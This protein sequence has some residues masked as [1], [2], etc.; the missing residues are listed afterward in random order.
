MV[1][2]VPN[3]IYDFYIY[4][5]MIVVDATDIPAKQ[6]TKWSVFPN[7]GT[8]DFYLRSSA[9]AHEKGYVSLYDL[10][11]RQLVRVPL[12]EASTPYQMGGCPQGCMS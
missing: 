11:G 12:Q 2:T 7:P 9:Q 6:E 4:D 1:F 5:P 8:Q 10:H 3:Y